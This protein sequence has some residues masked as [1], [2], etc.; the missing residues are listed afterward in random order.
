MHTD[1]DSYTPGNVKHLALPRVIW[2]CARKWKIE[3]LED[4]QQ[5]WEERRPVQLESRKDHC[6]L[7]AVTYGATCYS[8]KN[9]RAGR[10]KKWTYVRKFYLIHTNIVNLPQFTLSRI[11]SIVIDALKKVDPGRR[12]FRMI[13]GVLVERTVKDVLPALQHNSEQVSSS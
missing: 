6:S 12:C 11:F 3:D 13:G 8:W 4:G 9:I 1:W 7:P 10:G 2:T 5:R